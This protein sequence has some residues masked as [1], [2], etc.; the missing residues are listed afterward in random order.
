MEKSP[1]KTYGQEKK[2]KKVINQNTILT[3][4]LEKECT[5]ETIVR[6]ESKEVIISIE[7]PFVIIGE[8]INPTGRKKLEILIM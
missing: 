6:S 5:M 3:K 1:W 4:L 8:K 2:L 7:N